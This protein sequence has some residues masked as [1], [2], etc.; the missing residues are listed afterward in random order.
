MPSKTDYDLIIIGAGIH[1]AAVARAAVHDGYSVCVLE[2]Y[3]EAG[4]ATSSRSSKLIHGGLRYLESYQFKLVRDCLKERRI[5]AATAA[6]LVKL[7]PFYIPVYKNSRRPG[8]LIQLGLFIYQL[9]GGGPYRKLKKSEWEKLDG[10]SQ[11]DLL[12][13]FEYTDGL[14]DDK[15]LTQQILQRAIDKGLRFFTNCHVDKIQVQSDTV[16]VS[17]DTHPDISCRILINASGP[18]VNQLLARVSPAVSTLAVDLVQ[19]AHIIIPRTLSKGIYYVEADDGRVIFAIPW[20]QHC[21]LGTTETAFTQQPEDCKALAS[22]INYLLTTWNRYFSDHLR[23]DDVLQSFAGLRVLPASDDTAFKRKRETVLHCDN[24]T[25]PRIIS[26][27]GG[28]LTA[29]RHTAE[30]LMSIVHQRLPGHSHTDTS[31]LPL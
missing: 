22:E 21:L 8:W 19:G 3:T 30:L 16:T 10:L 12:A 7:L 5:L 9:L 23:H 4:L 28:K 6:S 29:H 13:V 14:T 26:I 25:A 18:W 2:Q 17:T 20:Q 24:D 11:K 15:K 1:G 27:Y 31:T